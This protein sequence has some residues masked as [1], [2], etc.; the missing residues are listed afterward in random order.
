M[1][2]VHDFESQIW[3]K[4]MLNNRHMTVSHQAGGCL[5]RSKAG[6]GCGSL[7]MLARGTWTNIL[8]NI[9]KICPIIWTNTFFLNM[10]VFP[11]QMGVG[12]SLK[13]VW[14]RQSDWDLSW[15]TINLQQLVFLI[16]FGL[17]LGFHVLQFFFHIAKDCLLAGQEQACTRFTW[18]FSWVCVTIPK[19]AQYTG[20]KMLTAP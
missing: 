20:K 7:P 2:F 14:Q 8:E 19:M 12:S 13:L 17:I 1:A 4:K 6:S 15:L 3:E 9:N 11:N 16:Q 10:I 5:R 18:L